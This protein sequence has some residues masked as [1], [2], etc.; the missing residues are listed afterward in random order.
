MMMTRQRLSNGVSRA[1]CSMSNA[2]SNHA[3]AADSCCVADECAADPGPYKATAAP[4]SELGA[5][6]GSTAHRFA[7]PR[8]QMMEA[9][10][11]ALA[12]HRIRDTN[13]VFNV[14]GA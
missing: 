6:P 10:G 2:S 5:G 13:R 12:L 3:I 9:P 4:G 8:A 7:L 11:H 1:Q 14:A